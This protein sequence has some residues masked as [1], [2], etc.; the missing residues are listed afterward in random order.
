MVHA[1]FFLLFSLLISKQIWRDIQTRTLSDLDS[2]LLFF[3]GIGY[4]WQSTDPISHGLVVLVILILAIVMVF[5]TTIGGGDVKLMMALAPWF[6]LTDLMFFVVLLL[7]FVS[8]LHFIRQHLGVQY[9]LQLT[10]EQVNRQLLP[11]GVP[12]GLAAWLVVCFAIMVD[13]GVDHI[14]IIRSVA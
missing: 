12:I 2:I 14:E 7:F 11:L 10:P 1:L 5:A 9:L 6:A 8:G 13:W 3:I 4:A